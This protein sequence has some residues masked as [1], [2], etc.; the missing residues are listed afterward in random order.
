M[1]EI[2]GRD[3]GGGGN[4]IKQLLPWLCKSDTGQTQIG[5]MSCAVDLRV[6]VVTAYS[7]NKAP[8]DKTYTQPVMW[9]KQTQS[10]I[11]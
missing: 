4:L 8:T 11:R 2:V 9:S 3:G 1:A 10:Q 5:L 7:S 6:Y